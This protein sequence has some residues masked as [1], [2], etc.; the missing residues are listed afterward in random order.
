MNVQ[1]KN[2]GGTVPL[3]VFNGSTQEKNLRTKKG[4]NAERRGGAGKSTGSLGRMK[5]GSRAIKEKGKSVQSK[6]QIV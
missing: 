4:P 5:K 3:Q 6:P 1:A 2:W